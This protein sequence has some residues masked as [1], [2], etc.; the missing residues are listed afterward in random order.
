MKSV[1]TLLPS[2]SLAHGAVCPTGELKDQAALVQIEHVWLR[3][4]E[5]HDMAALGC[6]LADEFEEADFTPAVRVRSFFC[7]R[8]IPLLE[9][10]GLVLRPHLPKRASVLVLVDQVKNRGEENRGRLAFGEY[11]NG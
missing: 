8:S 2:C 3:A 6:I 4:V 5:Q 7:I 1:F 11:L 9:P 10:R